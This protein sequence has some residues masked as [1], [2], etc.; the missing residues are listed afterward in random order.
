[1]PDELLSHLYQKALKYVNRRK[2]WFTSTQMSKHLNCAK[3][4]A[5]KYCQKMECDGLIEKKLAHP[6]P[7]YRPFNIGE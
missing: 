1:M 2:Q 3:R 5:R 4:T 6:A 7:K